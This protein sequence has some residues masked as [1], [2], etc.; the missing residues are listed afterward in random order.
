MG[1]LG[2]HGCLLKCFHMCEG[3]WRKE[4]PCWDSRWRGGLGGTQ[5]RVQDSHFYCQVDHVP[6]AAAAHQCCRYLNS[7]RVSH[8]FRFHLG[9]LTVDL[10]LLF[11]STD[12]VC[13]CTLACCAPAGFLG[14]TSTAVSTCPLPS[15]YSERY[16]TH[17]LRA[18]P[19][20]PP[21]KA[22]TLFVDSGDGY[23]WPSL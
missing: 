2:V 11:R 1:P 4:E 8:C 5:S 18:L 13:P 6:Q 21:P 16:D 15:L 22:R 3:W 7:T 20:P 17:E 10:N 14:A 12:T 9:L 19:H 23:A